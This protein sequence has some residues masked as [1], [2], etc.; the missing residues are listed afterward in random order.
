MKTKTEILK[1][2]NVL[3][4]DKLYKHLTDPKNQ[5]KIEKLRSDDDI[6]EF[7]RYFLTDSEKGY[8][9]EIFGVFLKTKTTFYDLL[10]KGAKVINIIEATRDQDWKEHWDTKAVIRLQ[11]EIKNKYINWK[12]THQL[13]EAEIKGMNR[14]TND[15]NIV[16]DVRPEDIMIITTMSNPEQNLKIKKK[17]DIRTW[18]DWG[19]FVE[20]QNY[21]EKFIDWVLK[22]KPEIDKLKLEI[23]EELKDDYNRLMESLRDPQTEWKEFLEADRCKTGIG[24]VLKAIVIAG[25]GTGK[26]LMQTMEQNDE[27]AKNSEASID[28]VE[29]TRD[30]GQ[31]NLQEIIKY[32]KA[33]HPHIKI[34]A[35][36]SDLTYLVEQNYGIEVTQISLN[37]YDYNNGSP[38]GIKIFQKTSSVEDLISQL[39]GSVTFCTSAQFEQLSKFRADHGVVCD[40]LIKDEVVEKLPK[41]SD[42]FSKMSRENAMQRGLDLRM[43][44]GVHRKQT[45]YDANFWQGAGPNSFALSNRYY[46]GGRDAVVID[47]PYWRSCLAGYV[48]PIGL[49]VGKV[50]K[51]NRKLKGYINKSN[52]KNEDD[53]SSIHYIIWHLEKEYNETGDF[54][55]IAFLH[56][57]L[58]SEE[59]SSVAKTYFKENYDIE[60]NV[61]LIT[62]KT[63][64]SERQQYANIREN[65][66]DVPTLV[67]GCIIPG[68]GFN[69]PTCKEVII[70]RGFNAEKL[71]H[72]ITRP[73]RTGFGKKEGKVTL[74]EHPDK[75]KMVDDFKE[76]IQ[77]FLS[78]GMPEHL[79]DTLVT[80]KGK[81]KTSSKSRQTVVNPFTIK[82]TTPSIVEAF[83]NACKKKSVKLENKA[84]KVLMNN[85]IDELVKLMGEAS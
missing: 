73:T 12:N 27:F 9:L 58:G 61:Q 29:I 30:L 14:I 23:L 84:D 67:I 7:L 66:T 8:L 47:W 80:L 24:T 31:Y 65:E 41:N 60:I 42:E 26:T 17:W 43:D 75:E 22:L 83:K 63:E 15:S 74:I 21:V 57:Q 82:F 44:G 32:V 45:V 10:F 11:G 77:S 51:N 3:D 38:I 53:V 33:L 46:F 48:L 16:E 71:S 79:V 81:T 19:S 54:K 6:Y 34:N 50:P 52:V 20:G 1:D 37:E 69:W 18:E 76:V 68:K 39:K 49:N 2:I 35:V 5:N 25:Q 78:M 64:N 62:G 40:L 36:C 13:T 72:V 59:L 55:T 4:I 70:G 85:S 56:T 28:W